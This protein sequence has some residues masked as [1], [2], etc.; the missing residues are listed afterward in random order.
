LRGPGE[1]K[2]KKANILF[3]VV[4]IWPSVPSVREDSKCRLFPILQNPE[5]VSALHHSLV[6]DKHF[7]KHISA[8][9][10]ME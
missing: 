4:V 9:A 10:T 8:L 7:A 1:L 3:V 6:R 2:D 5:K